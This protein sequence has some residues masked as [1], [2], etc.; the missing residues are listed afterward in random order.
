MSYDRAPQIT[1]S[2]IPF[3]ISGK[4]ESSPTTLFNTY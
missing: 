3:V 4:E 2:E 1:D